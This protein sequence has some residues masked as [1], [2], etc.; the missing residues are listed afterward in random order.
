METLVHPRA[1]CI[2]YSNWKY[3]VLWMVQ[4]RCNPVISILKPIDEG[5]SPSLRRDLQCQHSGVNYRRIIDQNCVSCMNIPIVRWSPIGLWQ[6]QGLSSGAQKAHHHT[7]KTEGLNVYHILRTHNPIASCL[8]PR[9]AGSNALVRQGWSDRMVYLHWRSSIKH[10]SET[11]GDQ[12]SSTGTPHRCDEQNLN[13][14]D[15]GVSRTERGLVLERSP[16]RPHLR[17][18]CW[19]IPT[20]RTIPP[21]VCL[22]YQLRDLCVEFVG[23][24]FDVGLMN[25]KLSRTLS[26][27]WIYFGIERFI[28]SSRGQLKF[29]LLALLF[30]YSFFYLID[31]IS[32]LYLFFVLYF[33]QP[34]SLAIY[35]SAR[36]S[37]R[38]RGVIFLQ[39][40]KK[41]LIQNEN[42]ELKRQ[43][44][45]SHW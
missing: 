44:Y 3:S 23:D 1:Y 7:L 13:R 33:G 41:K 32:F 40:K 14:D 42:K 34:I 12:I 27:T 43:I 38:F 4:S 21:D 11:S 20:G 15:P 18:Q 10:D 5:R 31:Q 37:V 45:Q 19:T 30:I 39:S 29:F 8:D 28:L 24:S 22:L 16:A 6:S 2:T 9:E 26:G 25:T 36:W 17:Y 35:I